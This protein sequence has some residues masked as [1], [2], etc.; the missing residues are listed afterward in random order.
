MLDISYFPTLQCQVETLEYG[1]YA[2][3]SNVGLNSSTIHIKGENSW[4]GEEEQKK[5]EKESRVGV[6]ERVEGAKAEEGRSWRDEERRNS[7]E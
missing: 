7:W 4:S 3:Q 5:E 1:I 2:E 6:D